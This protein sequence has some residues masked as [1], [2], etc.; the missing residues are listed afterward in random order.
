MRKKSTIE[1]YIKANRKG[2]RLAEIENSAGWKS[3]HRIHPSKKTYRRKAKHQ[4]ND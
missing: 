3:I 4:K 1:E 2:S